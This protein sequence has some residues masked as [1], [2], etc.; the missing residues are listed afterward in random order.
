M[1]RAD[2]AAAGSGE[3]APTKAQAQTLHG[4]SYGF[5]AASYMPCNYV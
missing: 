3:L 4:I 2:D 5:K 1:T